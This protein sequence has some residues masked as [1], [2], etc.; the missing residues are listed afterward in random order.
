MQVRIPDHAVKHDVT[1]HIEITGPPVFACPRRLAPEYLRVA[2]Q[3]FE[4]MLQLGI[5]CPSSRAWSSPLHMVPKK[6]AGNWRP[7]GDYHALNR[8]TVPKC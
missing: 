6:T 7:G 8:Y 3:E 4:H 2:R 1:H 5:V